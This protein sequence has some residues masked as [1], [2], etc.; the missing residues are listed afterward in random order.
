MSG[1]ECDLLP[2]IAAAREPFYTDPNA[3]LR[4]LRIDPASFNALAMPPSRMCS[5]F[6][7]LARTTDRMDRAS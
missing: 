5:R 7:L 1:C 3:V 4:Q 6:F 2:G